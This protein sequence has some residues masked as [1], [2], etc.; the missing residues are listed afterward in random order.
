MNKKLLSIILIILIII[1]III[2]GI[3]FLDIQVINAPETTI[4]LEVVDID[5]NSI[6]LNTSLFLNNPNPIDIGLTDLQ[7]QAETSENQL[8]GTFIITGGYIN[9][10]EEKLFSSEET[11]SLTIESIQEFKSIITTITGKIKV[12]ILGIIEK[13]IPFSATMNALFD[14]VIDEL[15]IPAIQLHASINEINENEVILTG[16]L[17]VYNPNPFSLIIDTFSLNITSSEQES[18]GSLILTGGEVSPKQSAQFP[19][20][21]KL[22]YTIFNIDTITLTINAE[23][24][25]I[26]AGIHQTVSFG[27]KAEFDVPD[28]RELLSL[29]DYLTVTLTGSFQFTFRGIKTKISL[30]IYNPTPLPLEVENMTLVVSRIDNDVRQPI[31]QKNM[32]VCEIGAENQKCVE[33]IVTLPYR[34]LFSGQAIKLLPDFLAITIY[35][36]TTLEGVNQHLPLEINGILDPHLLRKV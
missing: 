8:I 7:V 31:V 21:A 6:T 22:H 20:T 23:A 32:T 24:G 28:I 5:Q 2:M 36:E 27:T 17:D 1:N 10:Y 3:M 26:I 34:S 9:A 12:R 19:F 29:D 25:A 16:T 30:L 15:D 14:K 13:T 4:T 35:G 18:I 11:F 33:V